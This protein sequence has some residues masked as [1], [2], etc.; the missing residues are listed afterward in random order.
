VG[1]DE[2]SDVRWFALDALPAMDQKFRARIACVVSRDT[3]AR[4]DR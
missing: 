3:A 4:F 1:D 2:S